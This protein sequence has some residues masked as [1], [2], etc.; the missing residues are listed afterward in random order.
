MRRSKER[1]DHRSRRSNISNRRFTVEGSE[2]IRRLYAA[3]KDG[4]R[5]LAFWV[6]GQGS[7]RT[8]CLQMR[9]CD[10]SRLG[11]ITSRSAATWFTRTV[12]AD[13]AEFLQEEDSII[14]MLSRLEEM[15]DEER[16]ERQ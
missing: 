9:E 13:A 8:A 15:S 4:N 3:T 12:Q 16:K 11:G 1:P 5:M 10:N 6:E 2:I 14:Q 7:S